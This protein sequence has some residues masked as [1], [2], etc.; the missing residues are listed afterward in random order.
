M[1][2]SSTSVLGEKTQ[3]SSCIKTIDFEIKNLVY[4]LKA[5]NKGRYILRRLY[6]L[7]SAIYLIQWVFLINIV[8]TNTYMH[9]D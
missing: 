2:K 4:V 5:L 9:F 1:L 3:E 7:N 6:K 8:P